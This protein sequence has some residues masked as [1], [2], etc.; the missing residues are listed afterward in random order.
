MYKKLQVKAYIFHFILY[1]ESVW[2][3]R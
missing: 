3:E 2:L 1:Q